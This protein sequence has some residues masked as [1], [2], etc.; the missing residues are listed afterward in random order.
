MSEAEP[1]V[2]AVQPLGPAAE[3][4]VGPDGQRFY[5]QDTVVELISPGQGQGDAFAFDRVLDAR[6]SPADMHNT[7]VRPLLEGVSRGVNA[8]VLIIGV[9]EPAVELHAALASLALRTLDGSV[10]VDS[11]ITARFVGCI[12]AERTHVLDLFSSGVSDREQMVRLVPGLV[13]TSPVAASAATELSIRQVDEAGVRTAIGRA[14][15]RQLSRSPLSSALLIVDVDAPAPAA[16]AGASAARLGRGLGLGVSSGVGDVG[17]GGG[18]RAQ[19][20]L[21][22]VQLGSPSDPL[23]L[24]LISALGAGAGTSPAAAMAAAAASAHGGA[25]SVE[26]SLLLDEAL[27]GDC[28]TAAICLPSAAA[29]AEGGAGVLRTGTALRALATLP[30]AGTRR[31]RRLLARAHGRAHALR[32]RVA[33]LEAA[34]QAEEGAR[35]ARRDVPADVAGAAERLGS[36]V[37]AMALDGASRE[38]E[39]ERLI[40][41]LVEWRGRWREAERARA[42]LEARCLESADAA[43]AAEAETVALKLRLAQERSAAEAARLDAEAE[44]L[45]AHDALDAMRATAAQAEEARAA[46]AG[47]LEEERAARARA[48]AA[49]ADAAEAATKAEALL[50]VRQAE[51]DALSAEFV[52][53]S[54]EADELRAAGARGRDASAALAAASARADAGWAELRAERVHT[55]L[56][57]QAVREADLSAARALVHADARGAAWQ[58][59]AL[60]EASRAVERV[61]GLQQERE[62]LVE[63]QQAAQLALQA[64]LDAAVRRAEQAE[65][66]AAARAAMLVDEADERRSLGVHCAALAAALAEGP[67]RT[68]AQP[69]SARAAGARSA[70]QLAEALARQDARCQRLLQRNAALCEAALAARGAL[71]RVEP[72]AL[73][74]LGIAEVRPPA[75]V[76]PRRR[77]SR[78]AALRNAWLSRARPIGAQPR[79]ACHASPIP[80]FPAA[81]RSSSWTPTLATARRRAPS[82]RSSSARTRRARGRRRRSWQRA[83]QRCTTSASGTR[84]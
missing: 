70:E 9:G 32:E 6:A 36:L 39:R 27:G 12:G 83:A 42:E 1:V 49:A 54:A 52:A 59:R 79:H 78:R 18:L 67:D 45:L 19:F 82:P 7:V 10:G 4:H 71:A 20:M 57:Q 30:M 17:G 15:E 75:A 69:E 74:Q 66:L 81:R 5:V 21:L 47:A 51:L 68:D 73:A 76:A 43:L 55:S 24:A 11:S 33:A 46:A 22:H 77:A 14:R 26:V 62:E 13:G 35:A 72:T 80:S 84:G 58:Q 56:L 64:R 63:R 29:G 61:G 16:G 2:V 60:G 23:A 41:E 37:D 8:A 50:S 40:G 48:E 34:L 28:A 44:G 65:Q 53:L 31:V 3:G 38:S 25:R